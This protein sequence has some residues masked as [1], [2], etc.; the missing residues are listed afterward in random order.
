MAW[1]PSWKARRR[2]RARVSVLSSRPHSGRRGQRVARVG[3]TCGARGAGWLAGRAPSPTPAEPTRAAGPRLA[4]LGREGAASPRHPGWSRKPPQGRGARA[5][6]RRRG[7]RPGRRETGPR[8]PPPPPGMA[9]R[10]SCRGPL[11]ACSVSGPRPPLRSPLASLPGHRPSRACSPR[12][13]V[14]FQPRTPPAL[15]TRR[16]HPP[17]GFKLKFPDW[18]RQRTLRASPAPS[19]RK[20]RPRPPPGTP[21]ARKPPRAGH[22]PRPKPRPRRLLAWEGGLPEGF[23]RLSGPVPRRRGAFRPRSDPGDND[24]QCTCARRSF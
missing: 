17:L 12:E 21:G 15:R 3:P 10:A 22:A 14:P 23:A 11:P 2:K 20:P 9:V 24:S 6:G 19:W 16:L 13:R 8:P 5:R 4:T 1:C 18:G 7:P